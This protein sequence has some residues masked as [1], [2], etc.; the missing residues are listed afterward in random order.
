MN[1]FSLEWQEHPHPDSCYGKYQEEIVNVHQKYF[2]MEY[3]LAG[4]MSTKTSGHN[5]LLY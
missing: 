5:I 1:I 3:P 2:Q 4:I